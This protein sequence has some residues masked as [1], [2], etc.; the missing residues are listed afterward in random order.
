MNLMELFD[1]ATKSAQDIING[2][3]GNDPLAMT[4]KIVLAVKVGYI[5]GSGIKS[6][7]NN[8]KLAALIKKAQDMGVI[9]ANYENINVGGL[10]GAIESVFSVQKVIRFDVAKFGEE[11]FGGL[12]LGEGDFGID[13]ND[14][15]PFLEKLKGRDVN[16]ENEL[17]TA[18]TSS[19]EN[20]TPVGMFA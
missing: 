11:S 10:I 9:D 17:E 19:G 3:P 1:V 12:K 13:I 5:R 15:K 2:L 8:H 18:R 4:K 20:G 6:V 7:L 14:V 16:Y